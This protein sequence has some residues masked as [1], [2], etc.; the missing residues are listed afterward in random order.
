MII[1][2]YIKVVKDKKDILNKINSRYF[3]EEPKTIINEEN[4]I[5]ETLFPTT[6]INKIISENN[7]NLNSRANRTQIKSIVFQNTYSSSLSINRNQTITQNTISNYE[8]KK[9]L[10]DLKT[11]IKNEFL[12]EYHN[13][14]QPKILIFSKILELDIINDSSDIENN[15]W[16]DEYMNIYQT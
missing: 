2:S 1:Q 12:P 9:I 10:A 7:N 4:E 16:S 8:K 5:K 6:K 14:P 15:S 11:K 3:D 13:Y